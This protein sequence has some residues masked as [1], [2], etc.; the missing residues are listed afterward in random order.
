[1]EVININSN[2]DW[3][4]RIGK[5]SD[6]FPNELNV[7]GKSF[8]VQKPEFIFLVN[9]PTMDEISKLVINKNAYE[10]L[11]P[12]KDL[13]NLQN[14]SDENISSFL[15]TNGT[16]EETTGQP[17]CA[18]WGHHWLIEYLRINF[19]I[20][21]EQDA[22]LVFLSPEAIMN[23]LPYVENYLGDMIQNYDIDQIKDR[24]IICVLW[25]EL[26]HIAFERIGRPFELR[27]SEGLANYVVFVFSD[28][29]GK[30]VLHTLAN[31]PE[32]DYRR[33]YYHLLRTYA[34]GSDQ[35]ILSYLENNRGQAFNIFKQMTR[36]TEALNAIEAEGGA[37]RMGTIS[38]EVWVGYGA[39]KKDIA[40]ASKL[41][42]LCNIKQGDV[43]AESIGKI[44]GFLNNNVRVITH[45]IDSHE[46]PI[47]PDNIKIINRDD[48]NLEDIVRNEIMKNKKT[49]EEVIEEFWN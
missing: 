8:S 1:M 41:P 40:V 30:N 15:M 4:E 29:L 47:L 35:I 44:I 14:Q 38:G 16:I 48:A 31:N 28:D 27:L 20:I 7:L 13:N 33:N 10:Y 46:Y 19:E 37:F 34:S 26:A 49:E 23:R 25:H 3:K 43:I 45:D 32:M 39:N 36:S 6:L 2:L 11:L 5:F 9:I 17:G 12:L 18:T 21:I 22:P 24:I 42:Y